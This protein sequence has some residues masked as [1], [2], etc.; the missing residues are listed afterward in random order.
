MSTSTKRTST[1]TRTR[2]GD[3]I[4]VLVIFYL[5]SVIAAC[6]F[7]A[8]RELYQYEKAR[9]EYDTLDKEL[10]TPIPADGSQEGISEETLEEKIWWPQLEIDFDTY[11]EIN[12]DFVG[13]LYFPLFD[14]RYPV[15]ISQDNRDYLT[16]TFEGEENA[17]GC[18]FMDYQNQRN[19]RDRNTYIYGHNMRDGS[20]FGSLKRLVREP[21][22][23]EGDPKIYIY[24]PDYIL[25]YQLHVV[26]LAPAEEY[27]SG[28]YTDRQY[29]E[30][31]DRIIGR[32]QFVDTDLDYSERPRVL[33]LYTCWGTDYQYKLLV[34]GLQTR[35]KELHPIKL[36]RN[37]FR[38][39]LTHRYS[40]H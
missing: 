10:I 34:H 16:R 31:M 40:E 13:I 30:Y 18:I 27:L 19:F 20:M 3:V 22:L 28:I 21:A 24:T 11:R 7:L 29:D 5:V 23:C 9:R 26:E 8:G 4:T 39:Y 38:R 17:S 15:V 32:A 36:Y 12:E 14:M 1:T 2:A 6:L 25:E 37:S 35:I 33:S